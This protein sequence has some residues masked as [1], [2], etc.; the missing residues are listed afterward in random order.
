MYPG[1]PSKSKEKGCWGMSKVRVLFECPNCG[2]VKFKRFSNEHRYSDVVIEVDS[3]GG[4][5]DVED[6]RLDELESCSHRYV[7]KRCDK[8]VL[9]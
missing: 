7:C 1:R 3:E 9:N 2:G 5:T 4:L 8:R 6:G